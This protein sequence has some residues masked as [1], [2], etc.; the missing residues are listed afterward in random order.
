[1]E[2]KIYQVIYDAIEDI[3]KSLEGMLTPDIEEVSIGAA[4]IKQVFKIKKV[5][6]V[7]GCQVDRGVI[8]SNCKVRLFRNDVQVVE[9][10]L[11]TLKHYANDV[12]EARA[13][14][15]CGLSLKNFTDIKEGDVLECYILEEVAKKL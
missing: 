13:G 9:D 4:T 15:E 5:G 3:H 12:T 1:V 11:A 6:T 8:R 7:A 2:I 10:E 14:T